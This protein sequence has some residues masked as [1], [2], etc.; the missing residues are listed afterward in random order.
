MLC[1]LM[2]SSRTCSSSARGACVT[3][4]PSSSSPRLRCACGGRQFAEAAFEEASFTTVVGE[5]LRPLVCLARFV[6]APQ[7]PQELGL[8]GVQI[9]EVAEAGT[10]L[11]DDA[12][13]S[14]RALDLGDSN[15]AIQLDDRRPGQ[16]N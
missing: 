4:M 7:A 5:K 10:D 3:S 12:Q 11:V 16:S 8:R 14:L 2:W 15:G 9:A 1:S 6:E 13:T